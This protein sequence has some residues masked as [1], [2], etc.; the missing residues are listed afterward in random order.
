MCGDSAAWTAEPQRQTAES[1]LRWRDWVWQM[2]PHDAL[3]AIY[4]EGDVLA[5][6]ARHTPAAL[7]PTVL[8]QLNAVLTQSLAVDGGR[9]LTPYRLVRA[10][11]A[12]G[13]KAPVVAHP[14]AVRL[15]TVHG[16]KGLEAHTVVL[17]DTDA[18]PPK[19]ENMGVLIDWPG[20]DRVPR[21]LVFLVSEKRP[22]PCA[23]DL[24]L[25]EQSARAIEELNAL[26]VA[27]RKSVV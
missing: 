11:K 26:Y 15:L 1:L 6:Y 13:L 27:D 17:L 5:A 25:A 9:C 8:A 3:A 12:P 4:R 10:L 19:G 24:L 7:R 20:E 2:P 18:R 22:P 21:R 16:A 14:G 23:S